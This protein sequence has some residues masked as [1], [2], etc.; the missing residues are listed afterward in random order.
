M[1]RGPRRRQLVPAYDNTQ[2]NF[3]TA[4]RRCAF[5]GG[6]LCTDSQLW[7]VTVGNWQNTYL[8]RTLL[9]SAHWS[10]SF[11][12]NDNAFWL[13]RSRHSRSSSWGNGHAHA[14]QRTARP[15]PTRACP[16]RPS[17]TSG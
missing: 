7:P 6:D 3:Q 15:R 2:T 11:A 4:A 14:T 17:E 16:C 5:M 1:P 8:A 12:H 13:G 10:A 9:N